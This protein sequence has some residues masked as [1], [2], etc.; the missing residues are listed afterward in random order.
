VI[1]GLDLVISV[2]TSVAHLA[3]AMGRPTWIL[4]PREGLDWRWAD[5]VSSPWY[6]SAR[7][8]RQPMPGDWDSVLSE[9]VRLVRSES[10]TA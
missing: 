4:L 1:A 6:P 8:F 3:A 5:G 7:L 2:D 10:H 9:V